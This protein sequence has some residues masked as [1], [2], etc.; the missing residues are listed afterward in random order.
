MGHFQTNS[1]AILTGGSRPLQI[2]KRRK[3]VRSCVLLARIL[4]LLPSSSSDCFVCGCYCISMPPWSGNLTFEG[5]LH[6]SSIFPLHSKA[7]S[8]ACFIAFLSDSHGIRSLNF[9][10]GLRQDFA[11]VGEVEDIQ[12]PACFVSSHFAWIV[13]ARKGRQIGI[14]CV[15]LALL[16]GGKRTTALHHNRLLERQ[17]S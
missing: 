12:W 16:S 11:V 10:P 8:D 15:T 9:C 5:N 13:R 4:G 17:V 3:P 6:I 2:L 7:I 1:D 14:K